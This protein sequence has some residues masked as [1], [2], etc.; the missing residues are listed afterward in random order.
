MR[1]DTVRAD[2]AS[3]GQDVQSVLVWGGDLFTAD[4]GAD[5]LSLSRATPLDSSYTSVSPGGVKLGPFV[6]KGYSP[7]PSRMD[8]FMLPGTELSKCRFALLR[9]FP[10]TTH[11]PLGTQPNIGL[12]LCLRH[13][14]GRAGLSCGLGYLTR[15]TMQR[16]TAPRPSRAWHAS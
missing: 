2:T 12:L 6:S 13:M 14:D 9:G 1:A 7:S 5:V 16:S 11:P 8:T 4:G 3:D 10:L 15:R